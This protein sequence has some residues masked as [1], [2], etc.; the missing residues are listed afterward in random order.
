MTINRAAAGVLLPAILAML[1]AL[2][3]TSRTASAQD[4]QT[5]PPAP[6]PEATKTQPS[7]PATKPAVKPQPR[8]EAREETEDVH[9]PF[10]SSSSLK[11][12]RYGR[13]SRAY[14]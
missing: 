14:Y 13:A 12:I 6:V 11:V 5:T 4:K 2:L 10:Q 1:V 8:K 7:T 9:R 3:L